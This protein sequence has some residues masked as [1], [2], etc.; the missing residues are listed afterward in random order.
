MGGAWSDLGPMD[1]DKVFTIR[2]IENG[3]VEVTVGDG[4]GTDRI[5]LHLTEANVDH[6]IKHLKRAQDIAVAMS[7]DF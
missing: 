2:P 5:R 6:L 1:F 3:L 4:R 7:E